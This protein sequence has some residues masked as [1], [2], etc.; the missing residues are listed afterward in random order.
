MSIF[1]TTGRA[2]YQGNYLVRDGGQ[3][4]QDMAI[5]PRRQDSYGKNIFLKKLNGSART[6]RVPVQRKEKRTNRVSKKTNSCD[7]GPNGG[8]YSS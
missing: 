6:N 8:L 2:K 3:N 5:F 7:H 4:R 1:S